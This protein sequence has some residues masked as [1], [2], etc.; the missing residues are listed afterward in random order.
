MKKKRIITKKKIIKKN[1]PPLAWQHLPG[2]SLKEY[3]AFERYLLLGPGRS[4]AETARVYKLCRNTISKYASKWKWEQRALLYDNSQYQFNSENNLKQAESSR[5]LLRTARS[6]LAAN[7][8]NALNQLS[9]VLK[10][11]PA[12]SENPV[13]AKRVKFLFYISRTIEKLIPLT[14]IPYE[15][16]SFIINSIPE[17]IPE[18]NQPAA[19]L[20]SMETKSSTCGENKPV[21]NNKV[22]PEIKQETFVPSSRS[23]FLKQYPIVSKLENLRDKLEQM[24][25][26]VK[27]V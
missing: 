2:E 18:L 23:H 25:N 7:A 6:A 26:D 1:H 14:R 4:I 13:V 17:I 21:D 10:D 19:I 12:S 27:P 3:F 24:K 8:G 22:T 15:E 5:N 20:N 11:F 16:Q 9:A